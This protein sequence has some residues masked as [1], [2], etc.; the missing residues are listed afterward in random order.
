MPRHEIAR[1]SA[2]ARL[3]PGR[4]CSHGAASTA[5]PVSASFNSGRPPRE[6]TN[7]IAAARHDSWAQR[8]ASD[9]GG[10]RWAG[11]RRAEVVCARPGGADPHCRFPSFGEAHD[12]GWRGAGRS[13]N[14]RDRGLAR[15]R[16]F[17]EMRGLER[18][19]RGEYKNSSLPAKWNLRVGVPPTEAGRPGPLSNA[20]GSGVGSVSPVERASFV[21]QKLDRDAVR[22][23]V[24]VDRR[25][26]TRDR[27]STDGPLVS[28]LRASGRGPGG[29]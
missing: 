4:F 18:R 11:G 3:G 17:R 12:V 14:H 29:G 13:A 10:G 19:V 6:P 8:P 21:V 26:P 23:V 28:E 5:V 20:A 16:R 22:G 27:I 7:H 2:T 15:R 9:R 25:A 1:W 24:G